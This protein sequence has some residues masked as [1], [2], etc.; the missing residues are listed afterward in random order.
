MWTPALSA[1]A[2]T[3]NQWCLAI[4]GMC[5]AC[6]L[7]RLLAGHFLQDWRCGTLG[8]NPQTQHLTWLLC[9]P[10]TYQSQKPFL[11]CPVNE[12]V[13]LQGQNSQTLPLHKV[14]FPQNSFEKFWG[15]RCSSGIQHLPC[16]YEPLCFFSSTTHKLFFQISTK[17][18]TFP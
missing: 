3:R 6:A 8:K 13:P 2:G 15:W 9:L 7:T 17:T 12:L 11:G 4:P 18:E 14:G 1:M 16:V 10:E 5:G